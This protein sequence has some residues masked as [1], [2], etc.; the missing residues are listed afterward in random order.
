MLSVASVP[1]IS[2]HADATDMRKS[3]AGLCGIIRGV[4]GDD[5]ADGSLFLFVNKRRDRI[6]ALRWEGDGFMIW[7]TRL[8]QGTFEVMPAEGREKRVR[9]DATQLAMILGGVRL[10]SAHRRKRYQRIGA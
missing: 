7:Y 4:F 5:P 10:E 8:E 9:I 6:K 3:F 2:M 1:V